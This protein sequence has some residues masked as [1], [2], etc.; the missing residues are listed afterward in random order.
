M[1]PLL[2]MCILQCVHGSCLVKG[3]ILCVHDINLFMGTLVCSDLWSRMRYNFVLHITNLL[4]TCIL[5]HLY[6]AVSSGFV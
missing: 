2:T 4:Q 1:L 6:R 5:D 3:M